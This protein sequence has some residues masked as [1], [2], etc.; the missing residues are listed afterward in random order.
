[1][2][3]GGNDLIWSTDKNGAFTYLSPQFQTLFGLEVNEWI[4]KTFTDLVHPDDLDGLISA[5]LQS[6]RSQQKASNIEFRHLHQNGDYIWV[7]INTTP[8]ID[9][10]GIVIGGQGI[11][12]DI[13]DRKQA[14]QQLKKTMD[15]LSVAL[16]SGAIGCWEWE[17]ETNSL[18]WDERIYEL[19]A[20]PLGTTVLFET[21]ANRVHPD[22]LQPA[23]TLLQ[24]AIAGETEFNM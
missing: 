14:E 8:I 4:G 18:T 13:S 2:V 19:Y 10:E 20:V 3:E 11:L 5:Y 9:S 23:Q 12:A 1:M 17:L 7:S 22:D 16:K 15:R 6:V 21:W 24:Q